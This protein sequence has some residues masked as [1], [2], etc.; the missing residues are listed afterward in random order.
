MVHASIVKWLRICLYAG[1]K[2]PWTEE[3]HA[4]PLERPGL[5]PADHAALSSLSQADH[6]VVVEVGW[7][8][9]S[10]SLETVGFHL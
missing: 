4:A 9:L 7:K 1:M 6:I 3:D 5:S 10:D 2:L 8:G